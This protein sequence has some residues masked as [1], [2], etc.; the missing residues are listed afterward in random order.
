MGQ[1]VGRVSNLPGCSLARNCRQK[2][3][4]ADSCQ[5]LYIRT[6]VGRTPYDTSWN[7]WQQRRQQQPPSPVCS[8]LPTL[9]LRRAG[10]TGLAGAEQR[11][12]GSP[13]A[14]ISVP[15][16]GHSHVL[17]STSQPRGKL[18]PL[19]PFTSCTTQPAL[20]SRLVKEAGAVAECTSIG[21]GGQADP[22]R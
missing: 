14:A 21:Y 12:G 11:L 2:R 5:I 9:T 4:A 10:L 1:F 7:C 22:C 8:V 16:G 3:L 20:Q 18:T 15:E 13:A 19:A 17:I 6:K